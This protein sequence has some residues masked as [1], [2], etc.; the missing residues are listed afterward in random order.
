[1]IQALCAQNFRWD[2]QVPKDIRNNWK[3]RNNQLNLLKNLHISQR[4]KPPTKFD[5][6]KEI[7][8]HHFSDKSDGGSGQE[9]FLRF[10]SK[11]GR[12]N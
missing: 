4:F 11:T 6:I 7:S 10:V 5:R 8:I 2:D 12:I 1:M 9:N 3:K